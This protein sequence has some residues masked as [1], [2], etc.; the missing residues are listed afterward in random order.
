MSSHSNDE[1]RRLN[2]QLTTIKRNHELCPITLER[3][4]KHIVEDYEREI[5]RLKSDL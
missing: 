4:K 2:E 3:E 5:E 1:V